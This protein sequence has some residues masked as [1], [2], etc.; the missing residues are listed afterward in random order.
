MSR[1][2]RETK[3]NFLEQKAKNLKSNHKTQ[4]KQLYKP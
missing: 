1:I 4:L 2:L 3:A